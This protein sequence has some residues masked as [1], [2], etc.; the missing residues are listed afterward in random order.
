MV[1]VGDKWYSKDIWQTQTSW[2]GGNITEG[3]TKI[4]DE[5]G[6]YVYSAYE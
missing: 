5:D 1:N 6:R 2:T 3:Y 4:K